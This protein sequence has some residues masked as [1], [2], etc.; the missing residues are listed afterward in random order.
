[1]ADDMNSYIQ[2]FEFAVQ[3]MRRKH[4]QR[5]KEEMERLQLE[6]T[7][8][9]F[10]MLYLIHEHGQCNVSLLAEKLEVKP[11]AITVMMD[12]LVQ[13][14]YV[15]RYHDEK[16]RRVVLMQLT[17][18]GKEVLE[19]VRDANRAIMADSLSRLSPEE[20]DRLVTLFEKVAHL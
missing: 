11:S 5:F 15:H 19:K 20:I 3:S 2:R 9:Q 18:T 4:G 16:D 6:L 8:P 14:G 12:R 7:G 1:M 17:E 10:Y 13:A